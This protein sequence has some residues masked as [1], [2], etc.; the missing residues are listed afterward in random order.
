MFLT[1]DVTHT[2]KYV[3]R[4]YMNLD[5]LFVL[6]KY[7]SACNLIRAVQHTFSHIGEH[8]LWGSKLRVSLYMVLEIRFGVCLV[9]DIAC[10]LGQGKI[11]YP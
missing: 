10:I 9:I 5:F 2:R 11:K 1:V 6:Q 4:V 7:F 3:F 8:T